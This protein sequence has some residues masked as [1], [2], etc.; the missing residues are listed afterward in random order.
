M[1]V[2]LIR[3]TPVRK[4]I[5]VHAAPDRAF[6]VFT[7]RFDV[8]WPKSHHI[9]KADMKEAV[10]EPRA[11]GRWYEKG[12]DGSECDWGKVLTWEPPHRVVLSWR[13]NSRFVLDERVA[14]EVEITFVD[15]GAGV[16]RVDLEHRIESEDAEAMRS[17]VDAPN[18]WTAILALYGQDVARRGQK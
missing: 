8:W 1:N 7:R 14:S 16:T 4:T 11:G 2:H 5:R 6:D 15:E 10:L 9:G 18:G 12:I 17:S 3:V 13:I